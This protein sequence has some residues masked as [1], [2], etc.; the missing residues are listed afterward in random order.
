MTILDCPDYTK[1]LPQIWIEDDHYVIQS[2]DF[3]YR[4]NCLSPTPFKCRDPLHLLFK[5]C[6]RMKADAIQSTYA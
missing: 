4:I 1:A 3:S 5:L 6:R 2:A